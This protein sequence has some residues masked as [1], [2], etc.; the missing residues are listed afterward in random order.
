MHITL[1][2]AITALVSPVSPS[3][4]QDVQEKTCAP[5]SGWTQRVEKFRS[6]SLEMQLRNVSTRDGI[7]MTHGIGA[8]RVFG[9]ID[10]RLRSF[11]DY[12]LTDTGPRYRLVLDENM[13]GSAYTNYHYAY[14][15]ELLVE[16]K[17][18]ALSKAGQDD[19]YP[20]CGANNSCTTQMTSYYIIEPEV[21]AQIEQLPDN[22]LLPLRIM[23]EGTEY[24][25]CRDYIAA[26]E[27]KM[28]RS[29]I[30][31]EAE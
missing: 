19:A 22:R 10:G 26:A 7:I 23:R 31:R 18:V 20:I 12:K 28:L 14:S 30:E 27:F 25:P 21:F 3:G 8:K 6:R 16:G 29:A 24:R 17:F 4:G 2:L 15:L 1:G 11:L 9:I 13:L 5:S